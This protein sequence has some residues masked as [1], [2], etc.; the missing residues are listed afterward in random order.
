MKHPPVSIVILTFNEQ[1]NIAAAIESCSWC[2]DIHVLDSGSTDNTRQIAQDL[3]AKVHVN[4]FTSFGQ[5]RNWAIDHIPCKYDWQFHLDADER[6]TPSLVEEILYVIG[7][8][9]A[10]TS[11]GCFLCPSKMMFLSQWLKHSGGYPGYQARLIHRQRCRFRDV[12]HGQREE[13]SYPLGRFRNPY[14]H[15]N[16]SKG[17]RVWFDKHNGY[18]SKEAAEALNVIGRGMMPWNRLWT[19]DATER[20]RAMKEISFF[21]PFRSMLRLAYLYVLKLGALDGRAG[22]L[23]SL[24]VAMYEY[25]TGLKMRE[26]R[27]DW[28]ASNT[29]GTSDSDAHP[30]LFGKPLVHTQTHGLPFMEPAPCTLGKMSLKEQLDHMIAAADT[31][32]QSLGPTYALT[33][34]IRPVAAMVFT[35]IAR[36]AI[37]DGRAGCRFATMTAWFEFMTGMLRFE[38]RIHKRGGQT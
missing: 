20:R 7:P 21:M 38:Q 23:Y 11:K 24:M 12:G 25:W 19:G 35:L 32:A 28:I 33:A 14:I 6:F 8:S 22:L 37:L 30:M 29:A 10:G 2:D 9:G 13:T 4:P 17:L 3:G 31:R 18:S 34:V 1:E 36:K 15:F 27:Q 16:F 5:Q 26:V